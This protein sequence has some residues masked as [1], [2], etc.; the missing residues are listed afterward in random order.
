V[1]QGVSR[2]SNDTSSGSGGELGQVGRQPGVD[3]GWRIGRDPSPP[4]EVVADDRRQFRQVRQRWRR[5]RGGALSQR[6]QGRLEFVGVPRDLR[7]PP[8]TVRERQ[9]HP[10]VLV[11]ATQQCRGRESRREGRRNAG[12]HPVHVRREGVLVDVDRLHE[13]TLSVGGDD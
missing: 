10:A 3:F 12:L 9:R 7:V 8:V 1:H 13:R 11:E 5:D 4:V 2:E 6:A